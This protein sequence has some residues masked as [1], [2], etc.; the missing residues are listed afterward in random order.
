MKIEK[1]IQLFLSV[2]NVVLSDD[3]RVYSLKGH[4]SEK[5]KDYQARNV[6][7]GVKRGEKVLDVGSGGEPFEKATHLV[8]MFPRDTQHRY[9]VLK[10]GG[11]PFI[12]GNVLNL[13]VK[14]KAFDFV[15]C[16]HVL[17][18]V[19][20]PAKACDEL[21]RVARRGYVEVP[22]RISD[23]VFNFVMKPDFHKWHVTMMDNSLIFVEYGEWER[24]DTKCNEL[25]LLAHA[26]KENPVR[27]MF[28]RNKNLITNMFLWNRRFNYFVFDKKGALIKANSKK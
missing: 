4:S 17:E 24:Q 11:L 13:P 14:K 8:D 15:Y 7:F 18:H 2:F 27:N 5:K 9:N 19:D 21:M 22:T 12:Q 28:R 1:I 10:T 16:A 20:D 23:V 26:K 3:L 25:Y 6:K